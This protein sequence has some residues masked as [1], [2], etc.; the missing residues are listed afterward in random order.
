MNNMTRC[1][2]GVSVNRKNPDDFFVIQGADNRM[3]SRQK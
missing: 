1:Y 2:Y 3:S